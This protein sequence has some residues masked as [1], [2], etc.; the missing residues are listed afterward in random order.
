MGI[1]PTAGVNI[2]R[3]FISS[4]LWNHLKSQSAPV[5]GIKGLRQI[6]ECGGLETTAGLKFLCELYEIIAPTLKKILCQRVVDREFLDVRVKALYEFN[7][8][9]GTDF[10]N[11]DYETVIGLR[12][13]KDRIVIG[14]HNKFYCRPGGGAPIAKLPEYLRGNHVTLFGPPGDAKLSINAMNAYHRKLKNEPAIV[15]ELLKTHESLPKWGADDEDSKTPLRAD[16]I[17][18]GENLTACFAK[19]LKFVDEKTKKIYELADDK[20]SVPI[21]R[22]PGLALPCSFLFYNDVPLPLHLYDFA[23]HLF[24]NWQRPESLCFYVPKLEN[25]EEARYIHL[26]VETAEKMI[27]NLHPEYVLNSVRLLIVLENPRAVFRVNEMMDAMY[28]YFAGAS[29]GWHDYLASTARLFKEDGNYRIPVKADPY[30]VI[31]YIKAS[32]NLLADVVGSR[33]GIKIGGMYGI[34]PMDNDTKSLSFQITLKGFFKDVIT[35]LKR[36][37]SGFWVAHPDFIRLGLAIVEAFKKNK[38]E[39]LVKA[40]LIDPHQSEILSFIEKPD[41]QGLNKDHALFP[42][43]L[44]VADLKESDF[45]ANNHPEEI[46][47]NVFQSLQYLTDWLSGNGCVALPAQVEGVSVRVMDDLATAE[48]SRWEVWHEIFHGRFPVEEFIKIAF[49]ELNFIRKDLSHAKKIVQVKWDE[50][51]AKWYPIALELMINLMTAKRPPEFASELLMPFTIESIRAS[52]DPLRILREIETDKYTLEP[53]IERLRYYFSLCGSLS[54]AKP[55]AVGVAVDVNLAEK[56]IMNFSFAEILAAASFHGDIGQKTNL[57]KMAAEEQAMVRDTNE[58]TQLCEVY[59]AKFGMKFLVSAKGKSSSELLEVLKGRINNSKEKEVENAKLA[60]WEITFKRLKAEPLNLVSEKIEEAFKR[61]QIKNAQISVGSQD[62]YFGAG[63]HPQM[64]FQIAS[65]SKTLAC[66]FSLE[67]F[68]QHKISLNTSVNSLFEKNKS[69]FRLKSNSVTLEHL[70]NHTALNMH[71]VFGVPLNELLPKVDI[72]NPPGTV[73]QYSGGGFLVLEHLLECLENKSIIDITAPFFKKL[74]ISDLTFKAEDDGIHEYANGFTADGKLIPG[75]RLHFPAFA[76]GAMGTTAALNKFL[77]ALVT[78]YHSLEGCGPISHATAV[79]MLYGT[80]KGSRAFM[81]ADMGLGVFTA[82]CGPNRLMIHQGANDG[83]RCLYV[84]CF[85]GPDKNKGFSILCNGEINGVVFIA[86]AAQALLMGLKI[87][88]LNPAKFQQIIPTEK[89]KPEEIVNFAYKNLIFGAFENDRAEEILE[90]G[91]PLEPNLATGAKVISC[92]NEKFARAE[93]LFSPFEPIFDP[94][95]F[96]RQGKIMDSWESARHS[97]RG[98]EVLEFE[99]PVASP[100]GHAMFS[101]K[102]HFGNQ[103]EYVLLEGQV[104][105]EWREIVS[106]TKLDGHSVKYVASKD[107]HSTFKKFRLTTYPDGGLSRLSLFATPLPKTAVSGR[108]SEEIPKTHKPLTLSGKIKSPFKII[109]ATNEHYGPAAQVISPYP[110]LHMFDGLESAR[111]REPGHFEEVVIGLETPMMIKQIECDFRFF[112]NNNPREVEIKAMNG[113]G[114]WEV[115]VPKT[116]VKAYAGNQIRLNIKCENK[117]SQIK[118]ITYPDGGINRI[119]IK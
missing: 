116:N 59:K 8:S 111:S 28:P 63:T 13:G 99:I 101:T 9:Q 114:E 41:I 65:L 92:S 24:R 15:G 71:Y 119:R 17:Q 22:F 6:G 21:K 108:C 34:L 73:F 106:K 81:G 12:D 53:Y 96:G 2:Y 89:I 29:L 44:L 11:P 102:F 107:T 42:R 100:I 69:G 16:L 97:E 84:Y 93:N 48:R 3:E 88:G 30:I 112:I 109:S 10:L 79:Q 27:K 67:Y 115:I 80:D 113:S 52:A 117:I 51:T 35:Q 70:M 18:A 103:V 37:L 43:S 104:G 32:H 39:E 83:F 86:E 60:L 82:E 50:R 95:L 105:S 14:P 31:K 40:L 20:L 94:E 55:M 46:R 90:K 78:A 98:Y 87:R 54:F 45:I 47:Y 77:H 118:V 36:D 49:E 58:L 110:P 74:E 76:A 62:L 7:K 91:R 23:L 85:N 26:M 68:A 75:G 61:H 19:D 38:L 66:A 4:E 57:D 5:E 64:M 33:G 56:L 1:Q 72:A 25:E